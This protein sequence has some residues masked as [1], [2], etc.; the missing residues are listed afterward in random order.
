MDERE[1]DT[2]DLLELLSALKQHI[3]ALVLCTLVGAAAAFAGTY[4][5]LLP[6]YEA[7]AL[8]IVNTR[9]DTTSTVTSDQINSATALVSTYSIIIKSD[10]VLNQ[11]IEVLGINNTYDEVNSCVS[12]TSVDDTQVMQITVRSTNPEW[13]LQVCDQITK[14]APDVIVDSV[15]AGSVKVIS[16][17]QTNSIPVS[18]NIPRNTALGALLGLVLCAGI[19]FIQVLLDNKLR[20]E[21]DISKYLDLSVLGVIPVYTK[22]DM[23][24]AKEK[25]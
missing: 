12:V 19:V 11:V 13:A 14:I 25:A 21:E 2:I 1:Y 22:E 3:L 15:E 17:A 16:Q 7:Q 4:F 20:T 5:L 18:P 6:E 24:N 23:R 10:T 9:Q 8:M